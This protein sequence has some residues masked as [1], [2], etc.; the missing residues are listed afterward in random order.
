MQEN[1]RS[2]GRDRN[3]LREE[4]AKKGVHRWEDVYL[5]SLEW[6]SCITPP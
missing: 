4:L 2:I 5:A 6:G 3:K 1:L